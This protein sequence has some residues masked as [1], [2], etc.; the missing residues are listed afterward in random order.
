MEGKDLRSLSKTFYDLKKGLE[1]LKD[2]LSMSTKRLATEV[3]GISTDVKETF[4]SGIAEGVKTYANDLKEGARL[5][6]EEIKAGISLYAKELKEGTKFYVNTLKNNTEKY[7]VDLQRYGA[8]L[9]KRIG[10]KGNDLVDQAKSLYKKETQEEGTIRKGLTNLNE[11][12][13]GI[14]KSIKDF[15]KRDKLQDQRDRILG[16]QKTRLKEIGQVAKNI[17]DATI[18]GVAKIFD[19]N[20]FGNILKGLGLLA[21]FLSPESIAKAIKT[22]AEG[23]VTLARLINSD[24][25]KEGLS[26]ITEFLGNVVK[27]G[28]ERL[29]QFLDGVAGV[30]KNLDLE[31]LKAKK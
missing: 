26:V 10:E 9:V 24:E 29:T 19:S 30:A 3:D 8:S 1:G 4:K 18:K 28:L 23:F 20:L 14:R 15:F 25:F 6:S 22:V 2:S 21:L 5:Y 17:A 11:T 16:I 13:L 7:K 12:L 27:F 31:R